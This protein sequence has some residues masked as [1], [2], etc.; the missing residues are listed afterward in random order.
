MLTIQLRKRHFKG[1]TWLF[2]NCPIAKALKE[3][4]GNHISVKVWSWRATVNNEARELKY[5]YDIGEF[6][7]DMQRLEDYPSD[8]SVIREV[9]FI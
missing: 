4:Y 2:D 1:S 9:F 7:T 8:D 6:R 3:R 5:E